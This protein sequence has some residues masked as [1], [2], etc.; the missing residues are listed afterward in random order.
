MSAGVS[1]GESGRESAGMS[2]RVRAG[3]SIRTVVSMS[4][5]L[6]ACVGGY[7]SIGANADLDAGLSDDLKK[8]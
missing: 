1:A 8:I 2:E 4:V 5:T 3:V 7:V 6:S